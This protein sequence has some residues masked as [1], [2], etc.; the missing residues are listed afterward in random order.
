M[1]RSARPLTPR[2]RQALIVLAGAPRTTAGL[3]VHLG[4][5]VSPA[6]ARSLLA[7]L[8]RKGYAERVPRAGDVLAWRITELGELEL[9]AELG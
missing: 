8:E 6:S 7:A 9:A 4:V 3:A 2:Q 5:W 1:P